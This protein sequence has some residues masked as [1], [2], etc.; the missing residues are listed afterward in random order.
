MELKGRRREQQAAPEV[1]VSPSD[2]TCPYLLDSS[3]AVSKKTSSIGASLESLNPVTIPT[4][5][6]PQHAFSF[7]LF[8]SFYDF[9][10]NN[11][12]Q[13]VEQTSS[14]S[15]SALCRFTSW[16]TWRHQQHVLSAFILKFQEG[17]GT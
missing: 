1:L 14:S 16:K 15:S 5:M 3:A 2:L 6:D 9:Y 4:P 12:Q 7:F 13:P 17:K 10:L 8:F 11:I